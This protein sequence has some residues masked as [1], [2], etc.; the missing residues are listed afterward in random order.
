MRVFIDVGCN[1]GQ[2][3]F[4]WTPLADV[5][6]FAFEPNKDLFAFLKNYE[7]D[8]FAVFNYAIGTEEGV[9]KF[10]IGHNDAVDVNVIRLDT[11]CKENGITHIEHIKVDAQGSDL[12]VLKS[13]GEYLN[14]THSIMVEAFINN[15]EYVYEGEVKEDEV[16]QLLT[17]LGFVLTNRA[18]DGNY[19]DLTFVRP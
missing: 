8:K 11:F 7:S 6:V 1:R 17:P 12:D 5:K 9:K 10:N 16:M 13:I 14:V 3:A 15:H 4:N 19:A 2:Y 18:V